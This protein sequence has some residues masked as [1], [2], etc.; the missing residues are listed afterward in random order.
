MYKKKVRTKVKTFSI[1]IKANP[2][3]SGLD[4]ERTLF[5]F[6]DKSK[7]EEIPR[8]KLVETMCVLLFTCVPGIILIFSY[9]Y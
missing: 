7:N 8:T 2:D 4:T 6:F 5:S 3:F 1:L 9:C